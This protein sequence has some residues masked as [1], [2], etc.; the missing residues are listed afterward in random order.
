MDVKKV[1]SDLDRK[2]AQDA[3]AAKL[4]RDVEKGLKV[5]QAAEEFSSRTGIHAAEVINSG[6]LEQYP[7]G[8][9][10]EDEAKALTLNVCGRVYTYV[11]DVSEKAQQA[12]NDAA[13][14]GLKPLVP[15][16]DRERAEGIGKQ[17]AGYEN[18]SEHKEQIRKELVNNSRSIVDNTIKV[19][20]R[21]HEAAGLVPRVTRVY[22]GVGLSNGR[23]CEWC[24]ERC[25]ENMTY[26]EAY[27]KGAFQRHPGCGCEILYSVGKRTQRQ[28]DWTKNQWEEISDVS[29]KP[30]IQN[31]NTI[32]PEERIAWANHDF[33]P[34]LKNF[35][36]YEKEWIDTHF[37]YLNDSQK[38][39]MRSQ[40]Q[41][42][43]D[44][45][46]YHMAI[47]EDSLEK[48]LQ[49]GRFKSIIEIDENNLMVEG[50]RI[51]TEKAF[52]CDESTLTG[53]QHEKY[54][55]LGNRD[56]VKDARE[57]TA[58]GEDSY[59]DVIVR[60]KRENLVNRVTYTYNDSYGMC[61]LGDCIA[62]NDGDNV[63]IAGIEPSERKA[64]G[65]LSLL[66]MASDEDLKNPNRM[67]HLFGSS[68]IELQ[69]H[70]EVGVGDIESVCFTGAVKNQ[71]LVTRLKE[72]GIKVYHVDGE[73]SIQL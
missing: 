43:F 50:R 3:K 24:K 44:N 38:E 45:C 31:E 61:Q 67:A 12:T 40:M 29:S 20:A 28:T 1:L 71:G 22:D 14:V 35:D 26:Q 72:S 7:D 64:K 62:G 30:F 52:G 39:F 70:G 27:D 23:T 16:F 18:V 8:K 33:A 69:F 73:N 63:S 48:V 65:V 13:G 41:A 59:G 6:I 25:G 54:G 32:T 21:A 37:E 4:Q 9:I 11:A 66:M 68:Y 60:F 34:T 49:G 57:A 51:V 15:E 10:P 53:A 2:I 47:S 56:F 19:N 42:M 36:E 5:W 46:E 58:L 55:Y 17:I